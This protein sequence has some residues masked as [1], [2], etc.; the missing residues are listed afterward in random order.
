MWAL[1]DYSNPCGNDWLKIRGPVK[2]FIWRFE[3]YVGTLPALI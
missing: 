3:R 2:D 1:S